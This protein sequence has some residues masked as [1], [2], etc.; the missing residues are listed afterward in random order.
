MAAIT[1]IAAA[2][3]KRFDLCREIGVLRDAMQAAA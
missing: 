2:M 3:S 1:Q